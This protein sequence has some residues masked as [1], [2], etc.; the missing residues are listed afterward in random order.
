MLVSCSCVINFRLEQVMISSSRVGLEV[1]VCA[2]CL[3]T[4]T[5]MLRLGGCVPVD[6]W[7][8]L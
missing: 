7:L 6:D 3:L 5:S 8:L 4:T 2:A 1:V